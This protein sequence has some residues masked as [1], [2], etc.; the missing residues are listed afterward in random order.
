ATVSGGSAYHKWSDDPDN[1]NNPN[2]P[3]SWSSWTNL[4]APA[5]DLT[6]TPAYLTGTPAVVSDGDRRLNVFALSFLTPQSPGH[7]Y[8]GLWQTRSTDGNYSWSDW[9]RVPPQD[10]QG[11]LIAPGGPWQILTSPAVASWGP[12]RM[13][14]FVL[15][16]SEQGFG[17]W[18]LHTWADN[19]SWVGRW[20]ALTHGGMVDVGVAS[21]GPGRLD[22]FTRDGYNTMQQ[23]GFDNGAWQWSRG[24]WQWSENL[25]GP[26]N[27]GLTSSP[28]AVGWSGHRINV[29]TRGTDGQ[30][31]GT[32]ATDGNWLGFWG[33]LP[34]A[35]A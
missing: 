11:R 9:T 14:L 22:V 1:P 15:A 2:N 33:S 4:G 27:G 32:W 29:F 21:W 26:P 10:D 28:A 12:G 23:L 8:S 30:L 7:Y 16:Y 25:G 17:L 24:E 13:D 18:M 6:R 34:A 3:N 31:W 20:E 35:L 19:Y 5:R